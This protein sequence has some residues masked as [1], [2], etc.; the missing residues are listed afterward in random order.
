MRLEREVLKFQLLFSRRFSACDL[1]EGFLQKLWHHK[2]VGLL[3]DCQRAL[4]AGFSGLQGYSA[5]FFRNGHSKGTLGDS[6]GVGTVWN[7][8]RMSG[9]HDC[10]LSE[11]SLEGLSG[12]LQG[13]SMY[14]LLHAISI[15]PCQPH[16]SRYCCW[17]GPLAHRPS[18]KPRL[19]FCLIACP[20]DIS[21]LVTRNHATLNA[22]PPEPCTLP[23]S[24]DMRSQPL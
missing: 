17:C 12:T 15:D 23:S 13:M 7:V 14:F 11:W 2:G 21:T 20:A 8:C 6:Q 9:W 16:P 1:E 4:Q 22:Q 19:C 18:F 5:R 24:A 10:R 3:Q